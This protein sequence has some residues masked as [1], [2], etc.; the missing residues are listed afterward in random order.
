MEETKFKS[1]MAGARREVQD[2]QHGGQRLVAEYEATRDKAYRVRMGAVKQEQQAQSGFI[3][4]Y[5]SKTKQL[6]QAD[7]AARQQDLQRR[8]G[9]VGSQKDFEKTLHSKHEQQKYKP[10]R[11]PVTQ[12]SRLLRSLSIGEDLSATVATQ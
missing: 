10:M 9:L 6:K 2:R 8:R 12:T 3:A 5:D 4:A 7:C 1:L 11:H